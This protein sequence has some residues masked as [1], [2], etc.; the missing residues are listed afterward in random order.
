MLNRSKLMPMIYELVN[1]DKNFLNNIKKYLHN[2]FEEY[3]KIQGNEE[4]LIKKIKDSNTSWLTA[5]PIEN[6]SS[7]KPLPSIPVNYSVVAVDGSQIMPDHHE[8]R[9]CYLIN[10]GYV[11]L[12]YGQNSYAIMNSI[13]TLFYKEEELYKDINGYKT[14][15]TQ[16]DLSFKRTIME[17]DKVFECISEPDKDISMAFIDGTLIEWMVQGDENESIIISSILKTFDKAKE[18]NIPLVGYLSSPKSNDFI[19]M[20]RVCICPSKVVNCN[21]CRYLK[22]GNNLPCNKISKINDSD[23]FSIIL[24]DGERSPMFL[25]TSHILERYG[26]HKIAFFYMNTGSEISRIEIPFWVT[27]KSELVDFIHAVCYDQAKKGKGYP[28]SLQEAHEQ[29]V[30]SG[31]DREMFYNMLSNICVKNGIKMSRSYKSQRKRSGIL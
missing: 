31:S 15:I 25:S 1:N 7:I 29:A 5:I 27:E 3:K 22:S 17:Y 9:I 10:I 11:I 2:A 8:I 24:K 12:S 26:E 20:L 30:V 14:F 18:L 13:P 21:T 4:E 19:N 23:L 16:K 6:F 28:I